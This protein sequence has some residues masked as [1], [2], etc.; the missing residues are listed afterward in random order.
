MILMGHYTS[1]EPGMDLCATWLKTILP[2]TKI[3][4]IPAGESYWLPSQPPARH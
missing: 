4:F 2:R 3:D 1:E